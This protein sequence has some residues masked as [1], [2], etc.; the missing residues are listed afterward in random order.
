[1][2]V[3]RNYKAQM[4]MNKSCQQMM[5]KNILLGYYI[6]KKGIH[7]DYL[8]LVL[9]MLDDINRYLNSINFSRICRQNFK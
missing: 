7:S 6:Y 2:K 5:L 9:F 4:H 1:M 8:L 3:L